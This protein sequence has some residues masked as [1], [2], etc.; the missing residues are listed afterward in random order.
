MSIPLKMRMC[1]TIKN[2]I[3]RV[4]TYCFQVPTL[5]T[6]LQH[7]ETDV[8]QL[9]YWGSCSV[10]ARM[11]N[12]SPTLDKNSNSHG[13]KAVFSIWGEVWGGVVGHFQ[14]S[15]AAIHWITF[16]Q[17]SR[18]PGTWNIGRLPRKARTYSVN[19]GLARRQSRYLERYLSMRGG[20]LSPAA[21]TRPPPGQRPSRRFDVHGFCQ[22]SFALCQA[23]C[24]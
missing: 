8:I 24:H 13:S 1:D 14:I 16:C 17:A 18:T 15:A 6:I 7:W 23:D 19:A 2:G 22:G 9:W 21:S 10:P 12:L 4:S 20:I 3:P 5:A 11:P